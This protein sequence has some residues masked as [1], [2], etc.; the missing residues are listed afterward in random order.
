MPVVSI[1]LI[2]MTLKPTMEKLILGLVI[3]DKVS[4]AMELELQYEI[5]TRITN[6]Q[7]A[8][9]MVG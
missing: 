2:R 6:L 5:P 3:M 9:M 4:I 1:N 8:W 7:T